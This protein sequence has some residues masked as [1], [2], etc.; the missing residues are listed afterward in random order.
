M[1]RSGNGAAEPAGQRQQLALA[2]ACATPAA[3]ARQPTAHLAPAA[4]AAI[5]RRRRR[6][7]GRRTSSWPPTG[8]GAVRASQVVTL[9]GGLAQPHLVR[10]D[11]GC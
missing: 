8:T 2:G 4:A 11:G 10:P 9:D 1:T 7:A 6:R 5:G 3:A